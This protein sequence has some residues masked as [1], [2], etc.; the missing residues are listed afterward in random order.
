[1]DKTS[2]NPEI[3]GG[4]ECTINR[5]N[6]Q[7][8]DQLEYSG[9]YDRINDIDAIVSLGIT[10]IRYPILWE[11]HQPVKNTEIDWS[12]T[13]D[14]ITK[15]KENKVEIIAGLVHHGSGPAYTDLS[16]PQFPYLLA[17]YAGEVAEK[18]PWI[19]NY[20]PV[21]EPLTTARFS[22]LYGFWYPHQRSAHVF[23]KMLINQLKGT[24]LS[25]LE[26]RKI[27]P[28]ARLVQTEDLGKTYSTPELQYQAN[29]ENKR[30]W[31]TYDILCGRLDKHHPLWNYFIKNGIP[32]EELLFFIDN[33]C[34][35][36]IFGFNHYITSERFLDDRVHLYPQNLVGGNGRHQYADVEAVRVE[37]DEETGLKKLLK[38]AWNRYHSP[39]AITEVH[40]H[41][42]REE[43]LRWFKHVWDAVCELKNEN[44]DVRAVTSWA[45]LGSFGWNKLLTEPAGEYEP[46]AFDVRNG[47]PRATALVRFIKKLTEKNSIL[48]PLSEE[49]G[50]WQRS[51][52]ILFG[53]VIKEL[54]M[55]A[56]RNS[57]PVLII[58]KNGTLGK[59]LAKVCEERCIPYQIV[60][61]Q[62]CDISN[63]QQVKNCIGLFKPWAVINAAGYVRVDDAQL[64]GHRCFLENTQ[65]PHNLAIAC[66]E[67]G[68]QFITFSSDLV[69]DGLKTIPYL[70][71]DEPNPLNIYG[72][73]KLRAEELVAEFA[74]SSLVIRTS[75]FFSPWDEF[76]F[77]HY[78]RKA[79]QNGEPMQVADNIV[80]SPT[81]VPDLVNT[82]L[83]L[84]IDHEKG[85][86]H[87]SN[88]GSL[89]WS[90]FAFRIA[91]EFDLE[92]SL[93]D[94]K[95]AEE[96]GYIARRPGYS[97]LGSEK[98]QLLP[99]LDK[100]LD[101]YIKA[102]K[103]EKRKVA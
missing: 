32:Q 98:G 58:G 63:L 94:S 59:A 15:L 91:E 85:L 75:A 8:Y 20:T 18:F 97:V 73:S 81:Y 49:K 92:R 16:D 60:G 48:H 2:Y 44:I 37:I 74:P 56:R 50:W 64:D 82:T 19:N 7:Y 39:M 99:S 45:L 62:D 22:G 13:E 51:S 69:F 30:R 90:E 55:K 87:L 88:K 38:E 14:R 54:R 72:Q 27:N 46:G 70:E 71:S 76:N 103:K 43:Q 6:N 61:R 77:V 33:P 10:K 67:A 65:G 36:D 23:L 95:P 9:H 53:P 41:C 47:T 68:I 24:V 42:H 93:I 78:V 66:N 52:R 31:L 11:K 89:T 34:V 96:L 17:D 101:Q 12:W 102:E 3:W 1:M 35:P 100:A 5:V 40:L 83:D 28:G 25:M 80:I 57:A 29:F 21:N 4:I 84:L 86:W 26:I 79:L